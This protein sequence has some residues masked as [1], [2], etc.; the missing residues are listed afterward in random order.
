MSISALFNT[1]SSSLAAQRAALDVTSENIAN[2]NTE[3][4][5]RQ[6]VILETAP[7]TSQNGIPIGGGVNVAAVQRIY[8]NVLNKQINDG[9][10]LLGNNESK[11]NALLQVEPYLN[12]ISGNSIG[13]A[14]QGLTDAWQSLS[15]NPAGVS[16]RQTV[17]GKAQILVDTF[18][19]VSGG[20]VN[21]QTFADQSLT[22]AATDVSSK[23]AAI[24]DLNTQIKAT[25]L[26]SGNANELRDHRDL[27]LQQLSKIVGV[28]YAEQPDGT[29][30]VNLPGG[31]ALVS[32]DQYST[33]YTNAVGP[34]VTTNEIRVTALGAPPSAPNPAADAD[35]TATIGGSNNSKGEI[36]GLLY[37][38]DT[39][40]PAYLAKLDE[41]AYNLSYQVNTQHKAGWNL[42]NATGV[43][44]F[45][46]A[47]AVVP[48]APAATYAGYSAS[49]G[50]AISSTNEI[51]AADTNPL[52]GGVGNNKNALLLAGVA[53]TQVAF[54]GGV[55]ST[56]A[57]Y[58]NSLVAGVGVDVQAAK[59]LTT[60]NEAF[61]RQLD[62][63]RSSNS[64]VSLDEEL[65]NLIKYQKAFEGAS[66]VISTASQM[67]DTILGMVR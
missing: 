1:A 67:M 20:I 38:R 34:G 28:S 30:N 65:T 3:G 17:L 6:R 59:N 8:D 21:A 27:L 15:L 7:T 19:Q 51:A 63:L 52:L 56:T 4:Y 57:N 35:V 23:A 13:D 53:S 31:E 24:A 61:V 43:N 5:S 64:G 49:I 12:E 9:T 25:E 55:M 11:S 29:M 40:I 66:R 32:G 45:S 44:F 18:H 60:Q 50:V 62:N 36:G 37:A 10:T 48:P 2:V 46:P 22:A 26:A 16:E 33:L 39:T 47:T 41:L 54:S 58:Y 42:N 14:M